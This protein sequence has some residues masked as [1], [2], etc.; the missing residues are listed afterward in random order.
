M[1]PFVDDGYSIEAKI[2][3]QDGEIAV[4]YRPAVGD[5]VQRLLQGKTD[6]NVFLASKIVSWSGMGLEAVQP[7]E[8]NI[9]R[10]H[11]RLWSTLLDTIC[12]YNV[13]SDL[14]NS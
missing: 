11:S 3:F 13:E 10:L 9:K 12:G 6:Q 2:K 7:I 4:T 5:E 14:K 8:A 1:V